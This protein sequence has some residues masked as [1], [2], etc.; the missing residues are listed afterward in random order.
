M[1]VK[2][3][4][5]VLEWRLKIARINSDEMWRVL[6]MKS[7]CGASRCEGTENWCKSGFC[8]PVVAFVERLATK[9]SDGRVGLI[10][11]RGRRSAARGEAEDSGERKQRRRRGQLPLEPV[12]GAIGAGACG[13][14]CIQ[15]SGSCLAPHRTLAAP[16]THRI[17]PAFFTF[18]V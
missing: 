18:P 9:T 13:C 10:G 14:R 12:R 17:G 8:W 15:S 4:F 7:E 5:A 3:Y 1:T 6:L 11:G 2:K 16:A